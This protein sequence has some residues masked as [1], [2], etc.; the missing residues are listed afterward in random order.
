MCGDGRRGKRL[1]SRPLSSTQQV[2]AHPQEASAVGNGED[3][4]SSARPCLGKMFDH[5]VKG[6]GVQDTGGSTPLP[7]CPCWQHPLETISEFVDFPL[8]CCCCVGLCQR[9][10]SAITHRLPQKGGVL[11]QSHTFPTVTLPM[12]FP[13][14]SFSPGRAEDLV[15][16]KSPALQWD[17]G[18]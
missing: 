3:P 4:T 16:L 11:L 18:S 17:G 8:S 12:C 15:V 9:P 5:H 6:L 2:P 10:P 7:F 14:A 1:L 13:P